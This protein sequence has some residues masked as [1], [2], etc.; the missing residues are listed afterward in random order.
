MRSN[1][2]RHRIRS[3]ASTSRVFHW[4]GNFFLRVAARARDAGIELERVVA[5]CPVLDPAHTLVRLEAG[6][7]LYRKYFVWKW[8]RSLKKKQAAWPQLDQPRPRCRRST[9]SP[10]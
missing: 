3:V 9:T 6:W 7:A 4:G 5:V 2:S 8:Q 10:T 1:A